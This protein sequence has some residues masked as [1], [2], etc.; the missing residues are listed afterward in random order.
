MNQECLVKSS[1]SKFRSLAQ[2]DTNKTSFYFNKTDTSK[3]IPIQYIKSTI[4]SSPEEV[5]I[6]NKELHSIYCKK[7][8]L[9]LPIQVEYN[10]SENTYY[11]INGHSIYINAISSGWSHLW[12]D[13]YDYCSIDN[14]NNFIKAILNKIKLYE[15]GITIFIK[16]IITPFTGILY[17]HK[18]IK[19]NKIEAKLNHN[20]FINFKRKNFK[21][22]RNIVLLKYDIVIP[23]DTYTT[24]TIECIKQIEKNGYTIIKIDNLWSDDDIYSGLNIVFKFYEVNDQVELYFEIQFH[25]PDSYRLKEENKD[26]YLRYDS[27]KDIKEKCKLFEEITKRYKD[28]PIPKDI[29]SKKVHKLEIKYSIPHPCAS[30]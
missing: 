11:I 18:D 21:T 25:T 26:D 15:P 20:C 13:I 1:T 27:L 14:K 30:N 12:V 16:N 17:I 22:K 24:S 23:F 10:E 29:L 5:L 2:L 28:M 19:Y 8:T 4:T 3:Y 7:N 6:T 9:I